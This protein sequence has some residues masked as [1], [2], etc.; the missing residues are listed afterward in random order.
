MTQAHYK[1]ATGA[2]IVFDMTHLE[3]YE[4]VKKWVIEV[5]STTNNHSAVKSNGVS[6]INLYSTHLG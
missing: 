6:H 1:R 5:T 2:M 3:S 4:S